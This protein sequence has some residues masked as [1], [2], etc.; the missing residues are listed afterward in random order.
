MIYLH[1]FLHKR[2][3][4]LLKY[5]NT[6]IYVIPLIGMLESVLVDYKSNSI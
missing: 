6:H 5:K 3:D 4:L 1:V 2:Y